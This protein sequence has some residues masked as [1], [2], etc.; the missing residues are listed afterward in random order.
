MKQL[1]RAVRYKVKIV[2]LEIAAEVAKKS[3]CSCARFCFWARTSTK[4][5]CKTVTIHNAVREARI[6]K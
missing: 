4:G 6:K 5:C 2:E 1:G 3:R